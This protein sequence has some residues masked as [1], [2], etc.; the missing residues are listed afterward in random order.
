M[1]KLQIGQTV[2]R[3]QELGDEKSQV[4]FFTIKNKHQ[5][6]YH[7]E[8]QSM[9]YEYHL[10]SAPRIHKSPGDTQCFACE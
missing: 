10:I 7:R 5:L 8:F 4:S 2:T 3:I 1:L 6:A 9:D